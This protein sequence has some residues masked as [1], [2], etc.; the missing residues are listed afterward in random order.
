M[1]AIDLNA[2]LG[3]GTG[4]DLALLDIVSSASIA[5]GGHAGD[6][7]TMRKTLRAANARYVNCG[8]HPG[9]ADPEFFGRR[10]LDLTKDVLQKQISEQLGTIRDIAKSEDVTISYVKLHGSLANMCAE[11]RELA[12]SVFSVVKSIDASLA[13]LALDNTAQVTAATELGLKTI[14][15]AYADRR[16]TSTGHLV[17][18]TK[19][20]AVI[21]QPQEVI[22]QCISIATKGQI[23][24]ADGS[25][26][27]TDAKSICLHGDTEGAINLAKALRQALDEQQIAIRPP[28]FG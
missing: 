20:D 18:R 9:F 19:P 7:E 5:C 2:D 28:S 14:R 21:T 6:V 27:N 22:D 1:K 4:N 3:E 11:N 8:A 16:Y 10:R 23:I 26:L 24:A 12:H 17:P 25:V 15:E 13:I